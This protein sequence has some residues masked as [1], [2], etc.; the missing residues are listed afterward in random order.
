MDKS[1][2]LYLWKLQWTAIK[3]HILV[4]GKASPD[5]PELKEYWQKR[6]A[7]RPKYFFKTRQ[8]L[9]RRQ[10][11]KCLVCLDLIDNGENVQVHHKRPTKCGGTDHI[12]NLC[13]LHTNCHRQVH[14]K[15]GQ[16]IAAVSKLL[17]PYAE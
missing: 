14:S 8:I 5:N 9:W 12:N 15:R 3:R 4:K 10:E 6:Q 11:G 16:L 7:S 1:K 13:L 2:D 17:E